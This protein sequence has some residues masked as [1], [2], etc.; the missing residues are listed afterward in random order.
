M[1]V[2]ASNQEDLDLQK[3]NGKSPDEKRH[4]RD[5]SFSTSESQSEIPKASN[6]YDLDLS[7]EKEI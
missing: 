3:E 2:T 5:A 7:D 6:Q 4:A 1:N